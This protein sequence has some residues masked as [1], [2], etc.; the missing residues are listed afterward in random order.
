M[1][2]LISNAFN[3]ETQKLLPNSSHLN[4]IRTEGALESRNTITAGRTI[5]I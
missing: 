3:L 4:L 2:N 1:I 5:Y